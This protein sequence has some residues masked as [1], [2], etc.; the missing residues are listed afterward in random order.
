V[1]PDSTGIGLLT[2]RV[3]ARLVQQRIDE[4]LGFEGGQIVG[5]FPQP[6]QL[7]RDSQLALDGHDNATLRGSVEFRQ[8]DPGDIDNLRKHSGLHQT[9][10]TRRRIKDEQNF[11]DL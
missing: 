10:L 3:K 11:I 1:E 9:V 4:L 8:D 5:S 7:D 6:D 2:H